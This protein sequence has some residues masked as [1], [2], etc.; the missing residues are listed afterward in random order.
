MGE[1]LTILTQTVELNTWKTKDFS[2]LA[3]ESPEARRVPDTA[4]P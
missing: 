4:H 1:T 2:L 3:P